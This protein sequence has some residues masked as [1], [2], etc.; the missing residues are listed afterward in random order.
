LQRRHLIDWVS[1]MDLVSFSY[2]LSDIILFKL[3]N[4]SVSNF[5]L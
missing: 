2:N 1:T 3:I 4:E 5:K